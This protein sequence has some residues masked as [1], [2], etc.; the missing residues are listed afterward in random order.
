MARK[1][2]TQR[3]WNLIKWTTS[4]VSGLA[5]LLFISL[6]S[7]E[8]GFDER[9][10]VSNCLRYPESIVNTC[11]ED[12]VEATNFRNSLYSYSL[13]LGIGLPIVVLGGKRLIKYLVP[14][15]K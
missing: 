10:S 13:V 8:N 1:I 3:V 7:G 11:I 6:L 2:N 4:A 12:V 15:K 5:L 14:D 9:M